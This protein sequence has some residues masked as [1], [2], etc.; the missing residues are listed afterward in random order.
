MGVW[1]LYKKDVDMACL[2]KVNYV[3]STNYPKG[4]FRS[5]V[6]TVVQTTIFSLKN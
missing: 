3:T 2:K 6:R 4:T 5:Y 1:G